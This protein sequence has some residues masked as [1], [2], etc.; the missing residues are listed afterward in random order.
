MD[1][2]QALEGFKSSGATK[3]A[4]RFKPTPA[5]KFSKKG[6]EYV[7]GTFISLRALP[8]GSKAGKSVVNVE[9]IDTNATFTIAGDD[10]E[11]KAVPVRAGDKVGIFAPTGLDGLMQNIEPN[12]EVYIRCDG[13]VKQVRNGK[14][15]EAYQFDVRHK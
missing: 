11:Y 5:L 6:G 4:K 10:N 8:E 7:I 1:A 13:K 3:A 9:L 12:T 15:I 14:N 2:M